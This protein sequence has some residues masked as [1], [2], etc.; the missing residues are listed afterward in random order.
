VKLDLHIH[1][2][3][4][5]GSFDVLHIINKARKKN[6]EAIAITDHDT[7]DSV[8]EILDTGL[9][10]NDIKVFYGIEFIS[11]VKGFGKAHILG[12]FSRDIRNVIKKID[13][14]TGPYKK[15]RIT[16]AKKIIKKLNGLKIK[17]TYDEVLSYAGGQVIARPHIAEVLVKKG[18]AKNFGEAFERYIGDRASCAVPKKKLDSQKVIDFILRNKGI[19][20]IAHPGLIKETKTIDT[21]IASGINGIEVY[22]PMNSRKDKIRFLDLARKN[23]LIITGGSDYHMMKDDKYFGK[24]NIKEDD[25][26]RFEKALIK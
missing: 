13:M 5:D 4:S 20:V 3:A 24:I 22:C 6:L 1:T 21:L 10:F 18:Y 23:N 12:F 8:K 19:S 17:I 25:Y 15:A 16:R 7:M 11:K 14:F 26:Y 9:H 2:K